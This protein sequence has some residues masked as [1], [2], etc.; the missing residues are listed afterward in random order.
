M[1]HQNSPYARRPMVYI[2]I[3]FC[4]QHTYGPKLDCWTLILKSSVIHWG[5]AIQPEVW[6]PICSG[7]EGRGSIEITSRCI[8]K[9]IVQSSKLMVWGKQYEWTYGLIHYLEWYFLC[10][11]LKGMQMRYL[12]LVSIASIYIFILSLFT[13]FLFYIY[14]FVGVKL[15]VFNYTCFLLFLV[16]SLLVL[17]TLFLVNFLFVTVLSYPLTK[18]TG[19]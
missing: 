10:E 17:A 8:G 6:H 14:I 12:Y 7:I 9:I 1:L 19:F 5:I 2:Y 18:T 4:P 15:L 11:R 3:F 16:F 13:S